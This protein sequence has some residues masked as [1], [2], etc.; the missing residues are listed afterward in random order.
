MVRHGECEGR[1]STVGWNGRTRLRNRMNPN[2]P[3]NLT[4]QQFQ[5]VDLPFDLTLTVGANNETLTINR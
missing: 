4:L 2:R 5:M 1:A 3:Y